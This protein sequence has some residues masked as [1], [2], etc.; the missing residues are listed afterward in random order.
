MLLIR[1]TPTARI[2]LPKARTTRT[3]L[4]S[5]LVAL[6]LAALASMPVA[7][8]ALPVENRVLLRV[9]DRIVT[10]YA[11]ERQVAQALAAITAQGLDPE[12]LAQRREELP[13]QVLRGL[14]DEL[15][16]MSRADQLGLT[17]TDYEID[18]AVDSQMAQFGMESRSQLEQA[19]AQN[20]LTMEA[21]RDNLRVGLLQRQVWGRELFPR[22]QLAE[23]ELRRVYRDNLEDYRIDET[24]TVEE[25]VVLEGDAGSELDDMAIRVAAAWSRGESPEE[26]VE[27]E[28]DAVRY[29]QLGTVEREALAPALAD[30]IFEI[31]EGQ[32]SEPVVARGGLH[33]VKVTKIEPSR[34]QA[35]EEVRDQVE[36]DERGRRL[37]EEREE[38]LREL[39]ENAYYEANLPPQL[40]GFRTTTGFAIG[41][42]G[43][44]GI[45]SAPLGVEFQSS[46]AATTEGDESSSTPQG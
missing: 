14:W 15:L 20:G 8:Q 33:I 34:V 18:E 35:F 23:D 21:Y 37:E 36:I 29:I 6:L 28:G 9:N 43:L 13:K 10:Q 31:P 2:A 22:V 30:V 26:I 40:S 44:R 3:W 41:A 1:S 45:S 5:T 27:R 32:V 17:V 39:E 19:L 38:Y 4:R 16:I 11:Y 46:T 7:G 24:R 12:M 25:L 42:G